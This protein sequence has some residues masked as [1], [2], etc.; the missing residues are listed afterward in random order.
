M[1]TEQNLENTISVKEE[2]Q[3]SI[4]AS[5]DKHYWNFGNPLSGL[6]SSHILLHVTK[7]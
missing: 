4:P 5:R 6:L 7:K 2:K 3:T 1:L